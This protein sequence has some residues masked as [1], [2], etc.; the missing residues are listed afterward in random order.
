MRGVTLRDADSAG[1]LLPPL[2]A[3]AR[4]PLVAL[5]RR[6]GAAPGLG[7]VLSV[8]VG[9]QGREGGGRGGCWRRKRVKITQRPEC[10][11]PYARTQIQTTQTT[12]R[13]SP[14]LPL[15]AHTHLASVTNT[16]LGP[17]SCCCTSAN[18]SV[19]ASAVGPLEGCTTR[20]STSQWHLTVMKPGTDSAADP[21][22][23]ATASAAAAAAGS[24][25]RVNVWLPS[26]PTAGQPCAAR[27][28]GVS[29]P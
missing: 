24:P 14:S 20:S 28:G 2:R 4:L 21:A 26:T 23:I 1:V 11:Q 5:L 9:G 27:G 3:S 19:S 7:I 13:L 8:C 6:M 29:Q 18:A 22:A 16:R 17:P 15:S 10:M 25:A 12:A